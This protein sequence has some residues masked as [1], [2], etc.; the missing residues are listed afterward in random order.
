MF[1][2]L[3]TI[4]YFWFTYPA[5][6]LWCCR[7]ACLELF[8]WCSLVSTEKQ[9]LRWSC[10]TGFKYSI[11]R[12]I[13]IADRDYLIV[14]CSRSFVFDD[15][16]WNPFERTIGAWMVFLWWGTMQW[17]HQEG[18]I[19]YWLWLSGW[20]TW[21]RPSCAGVSCFE[22]SLQSPR[23]QVCNLV[24][25]ISKHHQFLSLI[26]QYRYYKLLSHSWT[27]T[28]FQPHVI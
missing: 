15:L 22:G 7:G 2:L 3:A 5:R 25:E 10:T 9:S 11:Y 26:S 28:P 23:E 14:K 21:C 20:A 19:H 4:S 1:S 6:S 24:S 12:P 8:S 17:D 18:H 13:Y 16:S 27:S